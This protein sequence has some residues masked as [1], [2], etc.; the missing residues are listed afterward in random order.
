MR[1]I[2]H[3]NGQFRTASKNVFFL[4]EGVEHEHEIKEIFNKIVT[5]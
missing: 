5:C 4:K 1:G 3:L 2:K